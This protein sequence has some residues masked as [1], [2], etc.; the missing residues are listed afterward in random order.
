MRNVRWGFLRG[1]GGKAIAWLG[2]MACLFFLCLLLARGTLLLPLFWYTIVSS[3]R[4]RQSRLFF[5]A[6]FLVLSMGTIAFDVR[7]LLDTTL[8]TGQS[9]ALL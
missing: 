9:G 4:L 2:T 8:P 3:C 7:Y 1:Q 5:V 6:A